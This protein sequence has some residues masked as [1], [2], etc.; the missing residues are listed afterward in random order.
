MAQTPA[1]PVGLPKTHN[2]F[3]IVWMPEMTPV[4]Y[5]KRIPPKAAKRVYRIG[6]GENV[7]D[8]KSG[9]THRENT[10]PDVPG[11]VSTD[12]WTCCDCSSGHE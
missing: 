12:A 8:A 1:V 6:D 2:Q 9:K 7:A 3:F 11:G 5:P 4:S 10:G